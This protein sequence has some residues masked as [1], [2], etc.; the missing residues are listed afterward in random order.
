M[1]KG[2]TKIEL[3][4]VKTGQKQVIEDDNLI[5]NAMSKMFE[6]TPFST[7]KMSASNPFTN[8]SP[9][10]DRLCGGLLL[11]S[12]S[13]DENP[14]N[15]FT[16]SGNTMVGNARVNYASAQDVPEFGA[17]N[18]EESTWNPET[19]ERKYVYD[20][21]TS[22]ANGTISCVCLT[23]PFVGY[24]G[25]GNTSGKKEALE[26]ENIDFSSYR[27]TPSD[28]LW[29]SH[30]TFPSSYRSSDEKPNNARIFLGNYN[31]N[32]IYAMHH[33]ALEYNSDYASEHISNGSLKLYKYYFPFTSFDPMQITCSE[34]KW[35]LQDIV[36]LE[37]PSEIASIATSHT[38]YSTVCYDDAIYIVFSNTSSTKNDNY[39][40]ANSE[41]KVWKISYDLTTSE[42]ITMKNNTGV[43]IFSGY[44]GNGAYSNY[45]Y[46]MPMEIKD[47]YLICSSP[48][49]S[50]LKIFKIK[51]ADSTDVV[52][53]T[54]LLPEHN[55][56]SQYPYFSFW[57]LGNTVMGSSLYGSK[58]YFALNLTTNTASPVNGFPT[59]RGYYDGKNYYY[60]NIPIVGTDTFVISANSDSLTSQ[61]SFIVH[62][63]F[64]LS[65][66]N[67]LAEPVVKTSDLAMKITYTLSLDTSEEEQEVGDS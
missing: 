33:Y 50:D 35:I 64:M 8:P 7:F 3:T 60:R 28:Y 16:P 1:L 40:P 61:Q 55:Y 13:I 2:H 14:D 19:G 38:V 48:S 6:Q 54:D 34:R 12:D 37:V 5:T 36:N 9:L 51:I 67:N 31:E 4:N 66:I 39:I 47:G 65:T 11:F 58:G 10:I 43:S 59:I 63:S 15:Y 29:G 53:F 18:A 44:K 52:E 45:N 46:M 41:F 26:I 42:V 30:Y 22:K 56:S 32:C 21:S 24:Y 49:I 25:L 57:K 23:N 20:F 62:N 17:Y 27:T